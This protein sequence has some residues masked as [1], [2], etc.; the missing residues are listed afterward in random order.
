MIERQD[1]MSTSEKY[2]NVLGNC[3][4]GKGEVLE[5]V[6]SPDNGWSKTRF[7]HELSCSSCAAEWDI[8]GSGHLINKAAQSECSRATSAAIAGRTRLAELHVKAIDTILQANHIT[9]PKNE[10][11]LLIGVGLCDEGPIRYKRFRQDGR[12]AGS[13]CDPSKNLTWIMTELRDAALR[14]AITTQAD[15]IRR[16]ESEAQQAH[17]S[18]LATRRDMR[19]EHRAAMKVPF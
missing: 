16:L 19:A 9:D 18:M 11:E 13:L 6:D 15:E 3:P 14:A 1:F 5:H 2:T 8:D 17:R 10:H 7:E 12:T 4:C